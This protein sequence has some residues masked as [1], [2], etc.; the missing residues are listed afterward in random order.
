MTTRVVLTIT[1]GETMVTVISF[2]MLTMMIW[3]G[4]I[5]QNPCH[6]RKQNVP[7]NRSNR[8]QSLVHAAVQPRQ[9]KNL[10]GQV[11]PGL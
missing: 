6:A 8:A 5:M 11:T 3:R 2:V 9:Q 4:E 1:I 7:G 10:A